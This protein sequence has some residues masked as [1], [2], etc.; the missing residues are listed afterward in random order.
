MGSSMEYDGSGDMASDYQGQAMP[1]FGGLN[2]VIDC[3]GGSVNSNLGLDFGICVSAASEPFIAS[4]ITARP[5]ALY[6]YIVTDTNDMVLAFPMSNTNFGDHLRPQLTEVTTSAGSPPS[7]TDLGSA[8][9]QLRPEVNQFT[10]GANRSQ[11][12][13]EKVQFAMFASSTDVRISN[14]YLGDIPS[15]NDRGPIPIK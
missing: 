13:I 14:P 8:P 9:N 3:D 5:A 2:G 6:G 11:F 1:T 7:S 12:Q 15:S 10:I 4:H